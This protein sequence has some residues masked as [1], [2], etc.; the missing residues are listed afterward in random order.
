MELRYMPA[1]PNENDDAFL[2]KFDEPFHDTVE[3]VLFDAGEGTDVDQQL[4]DNETLIGI[5]ITHAHFDHIT[6]LPKIVASYP[7]VPIYT[8]PDTA[9]ILEAMVEQ[10]VCSS[11]QSTYQNSQWWSWDN[12]TPELKN[13]IIEQLTPTT[14][15]FSIGDSNAIELLPIP[16]GHLSGATAYLV[17]YM[18]GNDHVRTLVTGDFSESTF[19]A[20]PSAFVDPVIDY[21]DV[22]VLV[23]NAA[24]R[25]GNADPPETQLTALLA[26]VINRA[27]QG[28]SVLIT[29]SGTTG[30]RLAYWLEQLH[31]RYQQ[32]PPTKLLGYS[33]RVYSALSYPDS[34]IQLH[35]DYDPSTITDTGSITITA[36]ESPNKGGA[37]VICNQL[38]SDP[39]SVI[40]Q[41]QSGGAISTPNFDPAESYFLSS[42]PTKKTF[43]SMIKGLKPTHTILNHSNHGKAQLV[44]DIQSTIAISTEHKYEEYLLYNNNIP[45]VPDQIPNGVGKTI[46]TDH[47]TQG[48]SVSTI[49][50]S[51][52]PSVTDEIT[53]PENGSVIV[54]EIEK[55]TNLTTPSTTDN[56]QPTASDQ[57]SQ[58]N[59][60][61][62]TNGQHSIQGEI[63]AIGEDGIIVVKSPDS[64]SQIAEGDTVNLAVETDQQRTTGD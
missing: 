62:K 46:L 54:N 22:D 43:L 42:H 8:S 10:A 19:A 2:L 36:P 29:A 6:S 15:M 51:S 63:K 33:A 44:D 57:D 50:I 17:Q 3:C 26:Q 38:Q 5:V 28:Q 56:K 60:K 30:V 11:D 53:A 32:V 58:Q 39:N 23:T 16:A 45:Q 18:V 20:H 13:T 27:E 31:D 47:H 40:F 48:E 14:E 61:Q 49:D 52:L 37:K 41:A 25:D 34:H 4:Q 59:G 55:N 64:Y 21:L 12:L 24:F 7:D 35:P 1:N 9:A